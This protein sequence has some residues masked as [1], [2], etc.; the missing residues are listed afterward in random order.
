MMFPSTKE[1]N[2]DFNGVLFDI[3][4]SSDLPPPRKVIISKYYEMTYLKS[5]LLNSYYNCK[6]RS[7]RT[8]TEASDAETA[9]TDK[10]SQK[11]R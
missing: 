9:F 4:M 2:Y 7:W 5:S 6:C 10:S 1:I 3:M 8:A 11:F